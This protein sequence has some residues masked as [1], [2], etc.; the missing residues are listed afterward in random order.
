MVAALAAATSAIVAANSFFKL[1][2]LVCSHGT[3]CRQRN[4]VLIRN[5]PVL[6]KRSLIF[7]NRIPGSALQEIV[8]FSGWLFC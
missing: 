3:R 8:I 5:V 2:I 4:R 1:A 7:S 6:K